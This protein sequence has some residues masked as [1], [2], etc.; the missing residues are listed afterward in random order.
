MS[1][2]GFLANLFGAQ[3]PPSD[4]GAAD[5]LLPALRA[6]RSAA[7]GGRQFVPFG[8]EAR[9]VGRDAIAAAIMGQPSTALAQEAASRMDLPFDVVPI[10]RPRPQ[11]AAAPTTAPRP[12]PRPEAASPKPLPVP[13][14]DMAK[15]VVDR[16]IERGL[17]RV[18]A[19]GL[20]ANLGQESAFDP[21]AVGDEGKSR[22][23]GQWQGPR[24]KA[25]QRFAK[26]RGAPLNEL[27]LPPPEVQLDF[28]VHELG[29]TERRVRDKLERVGP[30]I[31]EVT[32]V[33]A[34]DFFRPSKPALQRRFEMARQ[35]VS[36]LAAEEQPQMQPAA[37]EQP[38]PDPTAPPPAIDL[39][40]PQISIPQ[41][42][43]P[44]EPRVFDRASVSPTPTAPPLASPPP[45]PLPTPQPAPVSE[46]PGGP[47]PIA[48]YLAT[49]DVRELVALPPHVRRRALLMRGRALRFG[50]RGQD[51][52][53][54]LRRALLAGDASARAALP[55][56]IRA[57]L[58][59][60]AFVP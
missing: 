52:Q 9:D 26:E 53:E 42:E 58:G 15:W 43:P 30:D 37:E 47:G 2:F 57:L 48:R 17:P 46:G 41:V 16:L 31:I 40:A 27:G 21:N 14:A 8:E 45:A 35:L 12:Q 1:L 24:L 28:L 10:P 33:F 54:L 23:L 32:R 56:D 44:A 36:A 34:T 6:A 59:P 50:A 51:T 7:P 22:G 39:P 29:T 18:W 5:V 25:L 3:N 4:G 38:Q 13:R 55:E 60:D 20:A 49:G 19:L 11:T